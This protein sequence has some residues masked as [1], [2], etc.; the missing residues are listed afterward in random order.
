[1]DKTDKREYRFTVETI[2]A[3][4]PRAYADSEYEYRVEVSL[5]IFTNLEKEMTVKRFCTKILKP[6]HQT[7]KEWCE[8]MGNEAA[9]F[10][11]YYTIEKL[12]ENTYRYYVKKPF[13]D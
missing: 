1:M 7:Y 9:Y 3:G 2:R 13:C 6:C 5:P 4:Q 8:S 11:G 12:G 10:A